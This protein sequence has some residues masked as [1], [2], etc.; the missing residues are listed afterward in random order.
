MQITELSED[1]IAAFRA[2]TVPAFDLW[3][4]K[5]GPEIVSAFVNAVE[6][7]GN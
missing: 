1:E 7:N 6:E 3:A 4:E 5:I 2:E